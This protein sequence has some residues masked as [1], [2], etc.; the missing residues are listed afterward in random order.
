M[1]IVVGVYRWRELLRKHFLLR[2]APRHGLLKAKT[3]L[4]I[5][6]RLDEGLRRLGKRCHNFFASHYCLTSLSEFCPRVTFQFFLGKF[7]D[8]SPEE[9][10]CDWHVGNDSPK[11]SGQMGFHASGRNRSRF[12]QPQNSRPLLPYQQSGRILPSC[13]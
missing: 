2:C 10:S 8:V 6:I 9:P 11:E 7:F 5:D 4:C 1:A 12:V 3:G 13:S